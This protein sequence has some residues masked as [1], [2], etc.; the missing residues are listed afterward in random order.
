MSATVQRL[1]RYIS[2]L[3]FL[4]L[5][6]REAEARDHAEGDAPEPGNEAGA[7]WPTAKEIDASERGR[8][9]RFKRDQLL[10]IIGL[11]GSSN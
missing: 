11:A 4:S 5:L 6:G 9:E 7:G 10:P 3:P 8:A 2:H 1:C